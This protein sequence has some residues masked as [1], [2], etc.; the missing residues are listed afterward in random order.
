MLT[1]AHSFDPASIPLGAAVLLLIYGW[2]WTRKKRAIKKLLPL[3]KQY[4]LTL[5]TLPGE[6]AFP[7]LSYAFV[8][9]LSG[10]K[11]ELRNHPMNVKGRAK[12]GA[13]FVTPL[14]GSYQKQTTVDILTGKQLVIAFAPRRD[15]EAVLDLIP[16]LK[17]KPTGHQPFDKT[18]IVSTNSEAFFL[19]LQK[20]NLLDKFVSGDLNRAC[21]LDFD[22]TIALTAQFG[23]DVGQTG[24]W[25]LRQVP[26]LLELAALIEKQ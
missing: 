12:Q 22:G 18:W 6:W 19:N 11:V 3:A 26:I 7:A 5:T 25:L 4:D 23:V 2:N 24:E 8:G 20:S 16:G 14:R 13:L 1:A 10:R 21:S 15:I 17:S 9:T